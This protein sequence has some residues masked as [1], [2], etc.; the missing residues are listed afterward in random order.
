MSHVKRIPRFLTDK[1]VDVIMRW[2]DKKDYSGEK[3][4]NT[5]NGPVLQYRSKTLDFQLPHS[6][7]RRIVQPKLNQLFGREVEVVNGKFLEG[8]YPVGLHIDSSEAFY[9]KGFMA[10]GDEQ[11]RQAMLIALDGDPNFQTVYFDFFADQ[12]KLDHDDVAM[13]DP[14]Y[15]I[16]DV[17]L[18]HFLKQEVDFIDRNNIKFDDCYTWEVGGAIYWPRNQLHSSNNFS[19]T[20]RLKHALILFF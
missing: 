16:G 6:V 13:P 3:F 2:A 7:V 18:G 15:R 10:T 19:D 17:D 1:E 9:N 12:F 14:L 5:A 20:K 4:K 8:H 11:D